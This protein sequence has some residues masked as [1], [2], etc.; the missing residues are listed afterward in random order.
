[1]SSHD[2]VLHLS[3][4]DRGVK[5]SL[6]TLAAAIRATATYIQWGSIPWTH[7]KRGGNLTLDPMI[8]KSCALPHKLRT[9][10][11]E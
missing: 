8:K 4:S 1:M 3:V 6:T 9:H 2:V 11:T 5:N 7:G 10:L